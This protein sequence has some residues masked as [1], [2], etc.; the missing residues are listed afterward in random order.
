MEPISDP[1]SNAT[2]SF[3]HQGFIEVLLYS[4]DMGNALMEHKVQTGKFI[5]AVKYHRNIDRNV[6]KGMILHGF[7]REGV[8]TKHFT[9][10]K[11]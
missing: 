3:I 2:Y 10:T 8:V 5:S 1:S 11:S 7:G 4:R 6:W 9:W